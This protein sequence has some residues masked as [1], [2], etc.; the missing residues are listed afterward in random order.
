VE[1]SGQTPLLQA[2]PSSVKE[3]IFFRFLFQARFRPPDC[4]SVVHRDSAPRCHLRRCARPAR[5]W[6]LFQSMRFGCFPSF[7]LSPVCHC[8][9]HTQSSSKTMI[10]CVTSGFGGK[11]PPTG[12][13]LLSSLELPSVEDV[14]D[15]LFQYLPPALG[16]LHYWLVSSKWSYG[17]HFLFSGRQPRPPISTACFLLFYSLGHSPD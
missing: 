4:P 11:W 6:L 12:L 14:L 1:S 17:F 7:S 15:L 2:K 8:K 16:L 3:F 9:T 10:L 13:R 5:T